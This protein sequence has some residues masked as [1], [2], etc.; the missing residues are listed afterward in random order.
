MSTVLEDREYRFRCPGWENVFHNV[1]AVETLPKVL[2][3]HDYRRVFIVSSRTLNTKTDVIRKLEACMGD[4]VVGLTDKVGEH[5]PLNNVIEAAKAARDANADVILGVGGGSV[6]DLCKVMQLCITEDIY[7]R[8]ALLKLQAT[9]LPDFSDILAGSIKLPTIRQIFIPTTMATAEWTYGSTP[10]NEETHL[11]ANFLHIRLGAPQA[12]I[13]DP[14]ITAHTPIHL[15]LSTAIRGL[16]HAINTRCS[17]RPHPIGNALTEQAIKLFIENLP[18]IKDNVH[19]R[20]AMSNCQFALAC[21]GMA[22]MCATHGFSH[23][24]VH[25]VGPYAS[26]GHSEAACVLMLAQARWFEGYADEHFDVIKRILGRENEPFHQ[27]IFDLLDRLDMPTSFKDLGVNDQQLDEMAPL[28]M[29]HPL[30]TSYNL[31]PIETV[32]EI[33]QVLALVSGQ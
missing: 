23:W 10:M 4:K 30:V 33:R 8:E 15:L 11:K 6:M 3:L 27:I 5:A 18:L 29:E 19:D 9:I 14:E 26:V 32:D 25:I 2:E 7:E 24:M 22:Q 17:V 21:A 20:Q 16:D 1:S 13:Y 28:A 31:R 12:I